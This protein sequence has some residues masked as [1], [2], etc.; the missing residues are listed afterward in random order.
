MKQIDEIVSTQYQKF[1]KDFERLV[2]SALRD[3]GYN[4]DDMEAIARRCT[5]MQYDGEEV[6]EMYIDYGRDNCKLVCRYTEPEI[7]WSHSTDK[8]VAIMEFTFSPMPKN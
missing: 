2:M 7:K 5:V 1:H 8:S 4:T 6:R 3:L